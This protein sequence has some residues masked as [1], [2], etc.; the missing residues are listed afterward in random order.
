MSIRALGVLPV[1][2]VVFLLMLV[3]LPIW[4]TALI[5][6]ASLNRQ[7]LNAYLNSEHEAKL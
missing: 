2:V 7:V 1:Q 4:G 3:T 5:L 6:W